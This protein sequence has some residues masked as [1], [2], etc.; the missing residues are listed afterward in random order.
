MNTKS[1]A[2]C[3]C[4]LLLLSCREA[5]KEVSPAR[6]GEAQVAMIKDMMAN[7]VLTNFN[8]KEVPVEFAAEL[9][10]ETKWAREV[11]QLKADISF[12]PSAFRGRIYPE[13]GLEGY[14]GDLSRLVGLIAT[15]RGADYSVGIVSF[16]M[17]SADI[18]VEIPKNGTLV[19]RKLEKK[20][21]NKLG[22]ILSISLN[23]NEMLHYTIQ[24]Q[25]RAVLT[26][27]NIDFE[28]IRAVFDEE[29]ALNQYLIVLATSTEIT[30]R[31]HTKKGRKISFSD[32]PVLGAAFSAN[33]SVYVSNEALQRD[34]KV[35][36]RLVPIKSILEQMGGS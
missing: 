2:L 20:N 22:W 34:Y 24:D 21:E 35:G 13:D 5:K 23:A 31:T 16:A 6:Y 1:V 32:I 14:R 36:L 7:E 28:K 17:D 15:K 8:S 4:F 18:K 30:Y 10:K 26:D 25:A 27:S 12:Y 29:S 9:D 19:D 33:S 3:Y 11:E